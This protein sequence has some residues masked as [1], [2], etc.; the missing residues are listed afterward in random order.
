MLEAFVSIL[1]FLC[2]MDDVLKSDA[3]NSCAGM[4]KRLTSLQCKFELS[5]MNLALIC[6][7]EKILIIFFSGHAALLAWHSC[8]QLAFCYRFWYV[9]HFSPQYSFSMWQCWVLHFLSNAQLD[10]L[11]VPNLVL[12]HFECWNHLW[13]HSD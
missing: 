7:C 5:S 6:I 8:F 12:L 1:M 10:L 13:F 3:T 2:D 9:S 4:C 11:A